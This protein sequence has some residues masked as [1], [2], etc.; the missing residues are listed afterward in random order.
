MKVAVTGSGGFIGSNLVKKLAVS[1]FEVFEISRKTG[2][3][4]LKW[5]S[6]KDIKRCDVIIHLAA[7]TYVPNSFANP[8]NFYRTN[9]NL[10][11]NAL[12]LAR[13]WNARFIYM[14]SYLYGNP[15]YLPVDESHPI[16][17]HN[18]YA[19]TKLI[20]EELCKAYSRDFGVK[21]VFFRLFNIYGRGQKD[22]FLIP[23]VIEKIKYGKVLTLKDPR[24]KRDYI[25]I[26]DTISAIIASLNY[27][28]DGFDVFN[29]GTGKSRSVE[30]VVNT[31]QL[32][33]P[34]KFDVIYTH[35]YRKGEVLDSVADT[36]YIKNKL[37]W[38]SKIDFTDGI[39][40]LF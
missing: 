28:Y 18:P 17:P 8:G 15:I 31:I 13:K 6:I 9:I 19:E 30:E 34:T 38:E 2:F 12:E 25:H 22:L 20:S 35:E 10:T 1:N 11:L 7:K 40:S 32:F 14:S 29:L 27:E 24:P 23:E 33:S 37:N 3:N 4:L 5:S 21:G 26:D 39:K 36:S 16:S